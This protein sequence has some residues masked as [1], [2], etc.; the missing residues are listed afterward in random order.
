[1]LNKDFIFRV[2]NKSVVKQI[3]VIIFFKNKNRAE[4]Q[5]LGK[6]KYYLAL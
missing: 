4:K 2:L 3:C 5:I 6:I 1:M